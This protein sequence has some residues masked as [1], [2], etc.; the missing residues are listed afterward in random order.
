MRRGAGGAAPAA[1]AGGGNDTA[2]DRGGR[3]VARQRRGRI[4]LSGN[5]SG[6]IKRLRWW[7]NWA[8]PPRAGSSASTTSFDAT[9]TAGIYYSNTSNGTACRNPRAAAGAHREADAPWTAGG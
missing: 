7:A 2:V 4:Q 9:Y 6:I 1:R 8:S 3:K 5:G